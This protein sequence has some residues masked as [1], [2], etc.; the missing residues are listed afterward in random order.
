LGN[1]SGVNTS[2]GRRASNKEMKQ[3]ANMGVSLASYFEIMDHKNK[4]NKGKK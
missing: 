2:G 4:L 1:S 3:A